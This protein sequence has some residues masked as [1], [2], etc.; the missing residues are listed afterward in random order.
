MVNA[1]LLAKGHHGRERTRG[2]G[3]SHSFLGAPRQ[4]QAGL[5]ED[6]LRIR[7][8]EPVHPSSIPLMNL[9]DNLAA[10]HTPQTVIDTF[11]A[12][13][14]K[15]SA[16]RP[17]CCR[18][19]SSMLT[20]WAT[21]PTPLST[22]SRYWFSAPPPLDMR[23]RAMSVMHS[24]HLTKRESRCLQPTWHHNPQHGRS[25]WIL[26]KRAVP[27]GKVNAQ[28]VSAALLLLMDPVEERDE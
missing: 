23:T 3:Y 5:W 10:G 1:A 18:G 2:S 14:R 28:W 27:V 11:L 4:R 8:N 7:Y 6:H 13:L 15:T 26:R 9:L 19:M 22:G 21:F 12:S 16:Q 17:C 20:R 25:R 24:C